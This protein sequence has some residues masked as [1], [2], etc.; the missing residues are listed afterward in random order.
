MVSAL[1][2]GQFYEISV[3]NQDPWHVIGGMQDTGHWLGPSRVY[4]EEGITDED[5]DK[6]RYVGDGMASA[7]DP[8]DPNI[9]YLVQQFGN[10]SRL[11]MRTWERIELQPTAEEL[12]AVGIDGPVRYNWTPAMVLSEHDP[13]Y[14]YLGSNYLFRIHGETG[15][16]Q[17]LSD[18]L[19]WQQDRTFRGIEDGYHSY[20]TIFSV[21]ESRFDARTLW[22]GADDGPVWVTPDLGGTWRQVD[23]NIPDAPDNCVVAEIETSR[24]HPGRA[25]VALDCHARDDHAPHLYRTDDGGRSWLSVVGDLDDGPAYVIREDPGNADVLYVGVEHGVQVSIDGGRHWTRLGSGL[26]TVGVRT[27][28]VQTRDRDLAVGTFG[29]AIWTVDIGPMAEMADALAGPLHVFPVEPGTRFRWRVTYGN[30]IEE[31]NGDEMFRAETPPVGTAVRY[32]VTGGGGGPA[33]IEVRDASGALVRSLT[34]P[35][36]TGVH[37]VWHRDGPG[38]RADGQHHREGPRR[39]EGRGAAGAPQEV[40]VSGWRSVPG[41][42]VVRPSPPEAPSAAPDAGRLSWPSRFRWRGRRGPRR[43]RLR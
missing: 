13:D 3:D 16:V 25:Y 40:G 39:A 15:D 12:R 9:I 37:M 8:R 14:L 32:S 21:A 28:A 24:F 17:R 22:V 5:W 19:T 29:L 31:L 30:T 10:T 18:D 41:C 42:G 6:L 1:P 4:D 26:P 27:M 2:I 33:S 43:G 35:G 20:G 36:G 38:G 11:D 34:G 7:T 23:G